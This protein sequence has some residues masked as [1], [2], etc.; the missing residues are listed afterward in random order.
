M[1]QKMEELEPELGDLLGL[2]LSADRRQMERI[3][4][5][6][7][8]QEADGDQ[9]MGNVEDELEEIIIDNVNIE[10]ASNPNYSQNPHSLAEHHEALVTI[11]S[12]LF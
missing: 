7:K 11:V 10:E 3:A 5:W 4:K 6:T 1:A 12:C 9:V 8:A 2:M